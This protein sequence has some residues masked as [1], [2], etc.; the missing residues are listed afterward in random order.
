MDGS[1][2]LTIAALICST[3]Q[4]G[5]AWRVRAATPATIGDAMDVPEIRVPWLPLPT[6][7]DWMLTPGAEMSGFSQLSPLRGPPELKLAN[8]LKPGLV[9]GDR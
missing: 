4:S 5:C 3:F 1:P 7:V 9:I 2:V 6:R 8:C